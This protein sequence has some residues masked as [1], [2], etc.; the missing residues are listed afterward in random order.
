MRHDHDHH[1][2]GE[3]V[4]MCRF[5]QSPKALGSDELLF[6]ASIVYGD[7]GEAK[8]GVLIEDGQIDD[9]PDEHGEVEKS[10]DDLHAHRTVPQLEWTPESAHLRFTS[11]QM[12]AASDRRPG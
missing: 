4:K 10:H 3:D 1:G 11:Y 7:I 8:S 12:F 9:E 5:E 6:R 2:H